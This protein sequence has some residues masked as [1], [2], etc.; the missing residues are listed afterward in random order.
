MQKYWSNKAIIHQNI[1]TGLLI[2]I[3]IGM[4][5]S[6]FLVSISIITL[7][8]NYLLEGNYIQKLKRIKKNPVI[9]LF[10]GLFFLHILGL[11]W[12]ADF[13]YA[14]RD[15]QIKLPLLAVPV[16][17]GSSDQISKRQFEWVILFF[18]ATSLA[19]SIVGSV[20]YFILSQPGDDYRLM[21]PFMSHIRLSLMM[22]VAVFSAF[23][24]SIKS[25]H[26]KKFKMIFIGLGIWF[27][28][29]LFMLRAMSGIVAVSTAGFILLWIISSQ[30]E[31]KYHKKIK[32]GIIFLAL[33]FM[34]NII[35]QIQSFYNIEEV[36]LNTADTHS[37]GG[38]KYYFNLG[39]K[40]VENGQYVHAF[41]APE[42]LKA[43]WNKRSQLDFDGLDARGQNLSS[44]L[45]RYLTSKN[46]RKDKEGVQALTD[47]DIWA[48][49]NG[50]A[51]VRF[52][53]D[54]N[55]NTMI[56]RYI[57]EIHNYSTGLNPQGNS[58][59]Q[60]F[61]FW[62]VGTRILKDNW[63]Y[64]VG[65]GD[66]QEH[67]NVQYQEL[68]YI[69][70]KKYQLRAHNQ[71]LTMGITFGIFG[72]IYFIITLISGFWVKPNSSSYLFIGS[73]IIFAVSMLDEDTLETQFGVTYA[74]FFY[75]FF[76]FQQP[77]SE[78]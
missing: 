44:V 32:L 38:E 48:I 15:I 36:D 4:Q 18:L 11:L 66:V 17:L 55:I 24:M 30:K 29:Y 16:I 1:F 74:V 78:K 61:L 6:H 35:V 7:S 46:L 47:L 60:R 23:Y 71:Y 76:L 62:K 63:L 13:D 25:V 42:E 51:N 49:E 3:V 50:I 12:T 67:F 28:I 58:L 20:I 27:I 8:A 40:M 54:K 21:S 70:K 5:F 52:L 22:G 56:Y 2:L 45:S 31:F 57:W 64:G 19:S 77:D 53:D 65:T 59:G 9:I 69:I 14:S 68:P 72:L 43:E 26:W 73:F 33:L 41:I 75:F 34:G 39:H 37:K 10:V